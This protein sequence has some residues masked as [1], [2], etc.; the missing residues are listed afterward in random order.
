MYPPGSTLSVAGS[1][2]ELDGESKSSTQFLW[3]VS[4][5]TQQQ[6]TSARERKYT[7]DEAIDAAGSGWYTVGLMATLSLSLLA[8]CIDMFSL[9]TVVALATCD[10][11]LTRTSTQVLLSVPFIGPIVMAYMW[12][13]ISDTQG[14]RR[15][16][17]VALTVSYVASTLCAFAPDWTTLALCKLVSTCFCS[18]AQSVTYALLGE[19]CAERV[20]GT[21]LLVMSSVMH[22]GMSVYFTVAYLVGFLEFSLD[23]GFISFVP[24]RLLVV[25]LALPLGVS[26]LALS[27]HYESP[28]FLVNAGRHAEALVILANICRRN[29]NGSYPVRKVILAEV[30]NLTG[31]S[32]SLAESLW[33]QTAPLFRPPLLARTVLLYCLIFV[34]YSS[35]S[36]LF[37]W[38]PFLASDFSSAVSSIT[39]R[40]EGICS[41]ITHGQEIGVNE[42]KECTSK[43]G[44]P[45]VIF[46]TT[47]GGTFCVLNFLMSKLAAYKKMLMIV[48][49][50]FS[51]LCCLAALHI[52]NNLVN[53]IAYFG[54]VSDGLCMGIVFSYFVDLYP[55]SFRGMA[56][57]LGV[58]AARLS[59]IAGVNL[60][61][62]YITWH[63]TGAFYG[64]AGLLLCGA[65]LSCLL[66]A[67]SIKKPVDVIQ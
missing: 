60:I 49:L 23:L 65:L 22:L 43:I 33:Q 26:A 11:H 42:E 58:M 27:F 67:N 57:C 35:S 4:G 62:A 29:R 25:L 1:T 53:I 41:V 31:R 36:S 40:Q 47:A 5:H 50:C 6:E 2:S 55:T 14:R 28:K 61:G 64:L 12:G 15:S 30:G 20:K 8:M 19:C 48:I 52:P 32:R 54:I 56:A 9:S 66:P 7:Y 38:L 37:M 46:T 44:L 13:Y 51:S 39:S 3:A 24:W 59:S 10:L 18:C 34:V 16:L 21:Y 17:L 63:C 45:I